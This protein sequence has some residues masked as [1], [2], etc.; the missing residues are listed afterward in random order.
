MSLQ[1]LPLLLLLVLQPQE[2]CG[3]LAAKCPLTWGSAIADPSSYHRPG[4]DLIGG[5]NS[6]GSEYPICMAYVCKD[7]CRNYWNILSYVFAAQEVNQNLFP[8]MTLGYS[9]HDNLFDAR[10]TSNALLD[11]LS[12]G[13]ARVPNYSCGGQKPTMAVLEGSDWE[14]SLQISGMMGLYKAPQQGLTVKGQTRCKEKENWA[15]SSQEETERILSLDS[16]VIYNSV[17]AV[18][19]TLDAAVSSGSRRRKRQE[20]SVLGLFVKFLETPI[21]KPNN[22]DLSYILLVSLLL[23]FLSSFLFIGKP[24]EVTCLL[25]QTAFSITFSV[26]I[27]SLLAKTITVVLAFLATKP[28]NRV[29][30][31]LGKSLANSIVII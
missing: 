15:A 7:R 27:S 14:I 19:Q 9:V 5:L 8:N 4:D 21:V 24:R 31:W 23:S 28:G 3:S 2:T 26:A 16:H 29:R 18:T 25:R 10:L 13:Q 1:L 17:L 11:L 12:P 30:E 22:Q 6:A 20:G